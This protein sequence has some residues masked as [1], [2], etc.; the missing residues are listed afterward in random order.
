[1][2][3]TKKIIVSL[4][5]SIMLTFITIIMTAIIYENA[6]TIY[7]ISIEKMIERPIIAQKVITFFEINKRFSHKK[8]IKWL[9]FAI[10]LYYFSFSLLIITL[11][12]KKPYLQK[13]LLLSKFISILTFLSLLILYSNFIIMKWSNYS[14]Y[15]SKTKLLQWIIKL[16]EKLSQS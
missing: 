14:D 7:N 8:P 9:V 2:Q 10:S 13:I 15:T 6:K 11:F 1:M 16:I 3:I 4:V 5:I 12:E